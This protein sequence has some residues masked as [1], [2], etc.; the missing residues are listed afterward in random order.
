M[1][2]EKFVR[3]LRNDPYRTGV[4]LSGLLWAALI[5]QGLPYWDA[6]YANIFE[7]VLA[8]PLSTHLLNLIS[9][10]SS[11][12]ANW[13]FMDRTAQFAFYSFSHLIAGFHTWPYLLLRIL[14]LA[15]LGVAAYSWTLRLLP[16]H[17]SARAA[18]AAASIFLMVAPGT[19]AAMVW[20]ADFAPVTE[21]LL[22]WL[23]LK[24]WLAIEETP[25]EW[26]AFSTAGPERRKWLERWTLL[27]IATYFAYKTKADVKLL[28]PVAGLYLLIV[29]RKQWKLFL[30][31]IGTMVALALPWSAQMGKLPP[32]LPGSG[33]SSTGWMWQ[34]ASLDR[35][36]QYLWSDTPYSFTFSL[37]HSPLSLAGLLGPFLLTAVVMFGLWRLDQ[38]RLARL[39][40]RQPAEEVDDFATPERRALLFVAIWI[41]A[42]LAGMSALP[43]IPDYFRIR[44]SILVFPPLCILLGWGLGHFLEACRA[45]ARF[46]LNRVAAL[47]F[48]LLCALQF[49]INVS[50]SLHYRREL[51]GLEIAVD[52]AY[53]QIDRNDSGSE[54]AVLPGFLPYSW[55]PDHPSPL[56]HLVAAQTS[57]GLGPGHQPG[58]TLLLAWHA[59][60]DEQVDMIGVYPGCTA[61]I[62]FDLVMPCDTGY[63][64]YVMRYI[65]VDP[66]YFEATAARSANRLADAEPLYEGF[67][68][69]HPNNLAGHFWLGFTD[70]YL[71]KFEAADRHN[72]IVEHYLPDSDPVI[73]NRALSLAALKQYEPAIQRLLHVY[74][75]SYGTLW[76][77]YWCYRNSGRK[78]DALRTIADMKARFPADGEVNR[79]SAE[80]F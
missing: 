70:S 63:G 64:V 10:V 56:R 49:G 37:S 7:S 61:G 36:T 74:P 46:R 27:T 11:D 42:M 79:L 21:F 28:P 44:Y 43:P 57:A 62:V 35:L 40:D 3:V 60:L 22:A 39:K 32:F 76:N 2:A 16:M 45:D 13:G 6:D 23:A 1:G 41:L 47:A 78:Q 73:Y 30:V 17:R 69:A 9:P 80:Q 5:Q 14:S 65:G 68:A 55:Q 18:A 8:K 66:V 25:P 29:R 54:V 50:R 51:G 72:A 67:I 48:V 33:G 4:L 71:K 38:D 19:T 12:A 53:T 20:L 24:I 34:P 15:G 59:S 77:L 52:K 58:K 75:G 31:P 26:V